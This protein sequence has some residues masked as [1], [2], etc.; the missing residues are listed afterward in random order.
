MFVLF[1]MFLL[2]STIARSQEAKNDSLIKQKLEKRKAIQPGDVKQREV[3]TVDPQ[4]VVIQPIYEIKKTAEPTKENS[5]V[6][7]VEPTKGDSNVKVA[8]P[9]EPK[10]QPRRT[11]SP[12]KSD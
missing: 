9:Q 8:E 7:V 5:K 4:P 6:K 2:V 12:R 10:N 3:R 1:L 11:R